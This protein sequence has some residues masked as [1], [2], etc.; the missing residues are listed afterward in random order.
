MIPKKFQFYFF[1]ILLGVII[2]CRLDVP[3]KEMMQAR[4][5]ITKAQLVMAD[6]YDPEDLNKS[7]EQ[8]YACNT[9]LK[10]EDA[11]SALK[12]ANASFEYATKAINM[13]LP[14]AAGDSLS[15]S[16]TAYQEADKLYAEN[17]ANEPFNRAKNDIE[18]AEKLRDEQKLFESFM[19]SKEAS[20]EAGVAKEMCL[21]KVPQLNENIDSLKKEIDYLR[22]QKI[23]EPQKQE[24]SAA[25]ANLDKAAALISEKDVKQAYPLI[26]QAEETLDKMKGTVGK[27]SAKD[28][29]A[30]LRQEVE[31]LKKERGGGFAPEDIES[32]VAMINEADSL[33][34]Q[35]KI[36]A[37]LAKINEAEDALAAVKDKNMKGIAAAK[38]QK[39]E[40]LLEEARK[41]DESGKFNQEISDASL[42]HLEGKE[43][44][45]SEYYSHS[46]A[47][48]D[49]AESIL[50]SLGVTREKDS[51]KDQGIAKQ[52]E[53][54]R[55]YKVIYNKAKPDC[56]WRIADKV[57]KKARLWPLIYTAN[58]DQIK[59]P[60]LIFPGQTFV[61]PDIPSKK[62]KLETGPDKE[63][64]ETSDKSEPDISKEKG[65]E[66]D[67]KDKRE[68]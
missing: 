43:L 40:Q 47:K 51:L 42:L 16:K 4:T 19:K 26:S 60:D 10:N 48:L 46:V 27:Q 9:F 53:G 64:K 29:I 65:S 21:M 34:E 56:L 36:D 58:K 13:S 8:L 55:V 12:A 5:A 62:G 23:G 17:F 20:S 38:L 54:T 49:E 1:I 22:S 50:N 33:L 63:K 11:S 44:F 7:V 37:A 35:D 18:E 32:I 24:L 45:E 59:D 2:S 14:R 52:L 6:K 15:E 39:V 67:V 30:Q 61:I 25:S 57:Y 3:I 41:K 31:K 66:T 28:R 68:E